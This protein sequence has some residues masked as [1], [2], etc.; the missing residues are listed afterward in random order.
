MYV[1]VVNRESASEGL[2]MRPV[3]REDYPLPSGLV[4]KDSGVDDDNRMVS[5]QKIMRFYVFAG[6]SWQQETERW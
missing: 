6:A 5:D 4:V 3:G 1:G 2:R